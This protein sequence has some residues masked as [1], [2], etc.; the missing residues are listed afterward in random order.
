MTITGDFHRG[1]AFDHR[2]KR[3]LAER[4]AGRDRSGCG[5]P[6]AL[7]REHRDGDGNSAVRIAHTARPIRRRMVFKLSWMMN[8]RFGSRPDRS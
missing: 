3:E 1:T 8:S 5:L 7:R 2:A 4:G 6:I